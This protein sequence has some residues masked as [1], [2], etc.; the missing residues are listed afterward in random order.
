MLTNNDGDNNLIT[1]IEVTGT[2][3]KA[4]HTL[5][6]VILSTTTYACFTD[7]KLKHREVKSL[8]CGHTDSS[9]LE[10]PDNLVSESMHHYSTGAHFINAHILH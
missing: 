9:R 10:N 8:I 4:L 6:H 1:A 3:L 7:Y 5:V 2:V